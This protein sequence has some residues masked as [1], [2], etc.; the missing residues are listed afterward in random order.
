M[1]KTGF[2]LVELLVALAIFSIITA[3]AS[4]VFV[5]A[6]QSQKRVL[7]QQEL[8]NQTS[9]L[10]E[11]VSRAVR[12]AKKDIDGNCTG[13]AK[14]N[15]NYKRDAQNN[16]I[17]IKFKNYQGVC[18]EFYLEGW[19]LK[20]NKGGVI[21]PLTGGNLTVS[22]FQVTGSGWSQDDFSV[23]QPLTTFFLEIQ[24]KDSSEIQTQTSVSQRNLDIKQ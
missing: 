4:G 11:Y 18:Q 12:M 24:G 3:S 22:V 21:L 5:S 20:E 1:K 23:L 9:Y 2:T 13:T 7:A 17:G 8:L 10:M 6:I 15:Y 19:Q 14:L 16:K